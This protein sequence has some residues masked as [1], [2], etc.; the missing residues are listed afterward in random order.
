MAKLSANGTEL[1]RMVKVEH[2]TVEQSDQVSERKKFISF[3]SNGRIMVRQT[4]RWRDPGYGAPVHDYGWKQGTKVKEGV[5]I[6][7][8]RRVYVNA[9][10]VEDK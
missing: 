5:T 1:L 4:V 7:D 8:I 2:P 10:Y 9:G 6:G 3:R